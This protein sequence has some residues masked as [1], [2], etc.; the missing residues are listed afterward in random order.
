MG[1]HGVHPD[2]RQVLGGDAQADRVPDGR[3]PGLELPGNLVEV[4]P[5]QVDLAGIR[6][7]PPD[8]NGGIASRSSRLAH[9]APDPIGASILCPENA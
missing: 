2:A 4:A 9:R 6:F 1:A 3:R 5:A 8:R 7:S